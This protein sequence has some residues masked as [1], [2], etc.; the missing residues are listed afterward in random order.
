MK[1]G[2]VHIGVVP[3][4]LVVDLLILRN[5]VF[6]LRNVEIL[7]AVMEGGR[8]ADILEFCF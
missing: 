4:S 6:R 1:L 7:V 5:R 2:Y 8:S 3:P